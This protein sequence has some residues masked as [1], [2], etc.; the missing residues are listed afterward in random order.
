MP[1]TDKKVTLEKCI[2][3]EKVLC[4]H[5]PLL[6]EA[7]ILK[8][9]LKEKSTKYF[10]HYAG[11]N[12]KWDEWVAESRVV[13]HN[14]EGLKKQKELKQGHQS[15]GKRGKKDGKDEKKEDGPTPSKR[16]KGRHTAASDKDPSHIQRQDVK[17]VIPYDLRRFLLD[18]CDFVTRQK[19]LAPVPKP[20]KLTVRGICNHYIKWHTEKATPNSPSKSTLQEVSSG[21]C[22]YFNLMLGSH[23][24]YKFERLQ[25]SD[26][27]NDHA[28]K[29]VCE[30]YGA[31]H[32]L[33]MCVKLGSTLACSSLDEPSMEFVMIHVHDFLSF[34]LKNCEDL[35]ACEY[36]IATPDYHRRSSAC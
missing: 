13:K 18:D 36:N 15:K 7:K 21:I 28:G 3:G 16:R 19:Q 22:E 31:E 17:V 30:L 8:V 10:V 25:Y 33:R 23:L 34:V 1:Q 14:E 9:Q 24:L 29:P 27:L 32:L 12:V 20:P 5:G 6:Y 4:F 11:W 35:F 2:E 26:I